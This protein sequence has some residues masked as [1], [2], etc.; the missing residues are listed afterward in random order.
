MKGFG[1]PY[2]GVVW[3]DNITEAPMPMKTK[4]IREAAFDGILTVVLSLI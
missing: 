3:H 1:K 4:V 2:N